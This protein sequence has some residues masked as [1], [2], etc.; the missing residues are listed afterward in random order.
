VCAI[1]HVILLGYNRCLTF[2]RACGSLRADQGVTFFDT[3]N[4][5]KKE[6]TAQ[7]HIILKIK[8]FNF[9]LKPSKTEVS[10][11][12]HIFASNARATHSVGNS[13]QRSNS[14]YITVCLSMPEKPHF[15]KILYC[16]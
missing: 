10:T 1:A 15:H 3:S 7:S 9:H 16:L 2:V 11:G 14:F 8:Y 13:I 6:I 5:C 12:Y 4:D